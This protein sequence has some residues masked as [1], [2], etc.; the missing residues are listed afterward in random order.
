M[1]E[2]I[3]RNRPL[4][5]MA[6]AWLGL[7]I[8]SLLLIGWQYTGGT[9]GF[10]RGAFHPTPSPSPPASA[11]AT[12]TERPTPTLTPTITVT[13]TPTATPTAT[14][15]ASRVL[16][17]PVI[18]QE[19]PL[20]CESAG[21]RM[22]LAAMLNTVPSEEELLDCLP[23]NPNPYLGFRGDPAGRNRLPDG[24]INWENYGAYAPVVAETLNRCLLEPAGSEFEAFAVTNASYEQVA[25][26]ILAGYPVIVWVARG[27]QAETTTIET[28]EGPVL[29]VFGEHVWVVVG[30]QEDG[31]FEVHDPYPRNNGVQTFRVQSF[32]NW[33]LFE[34]MAVF[35]RPR[36]AGP[37]SDQSTTRTSTLTSAPQ[38][39]ASSPPTRIRIPKINVD[40]D[41]VEVGYEIEEENGEMVTVWK[42]ADFAA[43]FH[44]GSAYPGHPGNTVI[45]GHNNIRGR[46]FR[47]LLDLLP[48]DNIYLYVGEQEFRYAVAERLLIKEKGMPEEIR[49]ENAQWIQP[50]DDERLT[51][52][53]CWPFIKPDHRVVVIA[54]PIHE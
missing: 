52:V 23:R 8:V 44:L 25:E 53:S 46:V 35:V 1:G 20:S 24:S 19:L 31:T 17:V 38:P 15:L 10:P 9:D 30:F 13:P 33:D 28:P 11:T 47:H 14:L 29:L 40:A 7:L 50:T 39:A 18:L 6:A 54:R 51:L 26:A 37:A 32:P 48:E 49:R 16:S 12:Q 36:E 34:R 22:V 42:V 3:R 4:S 2:W 5:I 45:A 41:V 27:D 43:G 21:M